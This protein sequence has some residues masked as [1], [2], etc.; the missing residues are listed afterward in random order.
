MTDLS[1]LPPPAPG[2]PEGYYPDPLGGR[3]GRWWDGERWHSRVG[4]EM[5][6]PA[7]GE[8]PL[9][10]AP[11]VGEGPLKPS[12]PGS[13]K[14]KAID[15]GGP[16]GA[17]FHMYRRYP[18]MFFLLAVG[19]VVPYDLIAL[20]I[21]AVGPNSHA[22]ADLGAQLVLTL[23]DWVLVSPFVSALHVHALADIREG[24]EPRLGPVARRGLRVLPVVAA[25]TIMA[26]LGTVL[27]MLALI[28]PGVILFFRWFVVAQVAAIE[29]QGW[30]PA[31]KRS[32]QLTKD[33]WLAI[34]LFL[35]ITAVIL[36]IPNAVV[37]VGF[38]PED[39]SAGS[40]AAGIAVHVLNTSFA[41]L[42]IGACYFMLADRLA[43]RDPKQSF[44]SD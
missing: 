6:P 5:E 44:P 41:A 10:Q 25:A 35:L 34:F 38:G 39:T 17:A 29:Q 22:A 2:A 42:S 18:V 16:V 8:R 14:S 30:L 40:V 1:Q 37:G 26:G 19:V 36:A 13:T 27:G 21:T 3:F 23:L 32:P 31:L 12:S 28:V 11:P 4:P 43:G 9:P 24:T 7:P 33:N 20:A 15:P